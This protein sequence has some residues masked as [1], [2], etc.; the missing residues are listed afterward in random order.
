MSSWFWD[1]CEWFRGFLQGEF[2]GEPGPFLFSH[3]WYG[4]WLLAGER[5]REHHIKLAAETRR[6]IKR[7]CFFEHMVHEWR[8]LLQML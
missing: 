3:E 6:D 5:R 7:G 8:S 2:R 4:E 1:E